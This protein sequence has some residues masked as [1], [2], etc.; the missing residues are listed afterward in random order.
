MPVS[1]ANLNKDEFSENELNYQLGEVIYDDNL[2]VHKRVETGFMPPRVI[3]RS[4]STSVLAG[5]IKRLARIKI[6]RDAQF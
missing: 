4:Y 2:F 6:F 5:R 1:V 3:W